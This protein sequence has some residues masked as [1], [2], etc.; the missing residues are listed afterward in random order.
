[1]N[2]DGYTLFWLILL[3][4]RTQE[5]PC[6]TVKSTVL[7]F[8]SVGKTRSA[9]IAQ[10]WYT[11]STSTLVD[12]IMG[13]G[14]IRFMSIFTAKREKEPV[15]NN[16]LAELNEKLSDLQ[17]RQQISQRLLTEATNE[18]MPL[19]TMQRRVDQERPRLVQAR[20][21][22]HYAAQEAEQALDSAI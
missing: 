1:M 16:P 18:L 10:F 21:S 15:A 20:Q 5:G 8:E 12:N 22:A 13:K 2:T 6:C 3:M 9:I 4:D 14:K 19:L 17:S 7:L 11:V